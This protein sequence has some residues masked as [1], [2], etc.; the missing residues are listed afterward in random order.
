MDAGPVVRE[1]DGQ[2]SEKTTLARGASILVLFNASV[3]PSWSGTT[4]IHYVGTSSGRVVA[5]EDRWAG[6]E[7]H[8]APVTDGCKRPRSPKPPASRCIKPRPV[9]FPP[10]KAHS[11]VKERAIPRGTIAGNGNSH[12]VG[13]S[14]RNYF[15]AHVEQL[16]E[17]NEASARGRYMCDV[18]ERKQGSHTEIDVVRP[19]MPPTPGGLGDKRSSALLRLSRSKHS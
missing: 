14:G 11:P 15:G 10:R 1:V 9:C 19:D 12:S 18:L 8:V 17:R 7:I 16:Y 6:T 4:R 5:R 2:W 13:K 3:V